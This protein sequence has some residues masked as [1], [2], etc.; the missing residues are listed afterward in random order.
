[1]LPRIVYE[2]GIA[3]LFE[4]P[5]TARAL[6]LQLVGGIIYRLRF[7]RGDQEIARTTVDMRG[8]AAFPADPRLHDQEVQVPAEAAGFTAVLVDALN[9]N[10][11]HV[12]CVGSLVPVQG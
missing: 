9:P 4:Q 3:V 6:R 2:G 11:E 8:M 5:I 7:V 1:V 12:G 10:S